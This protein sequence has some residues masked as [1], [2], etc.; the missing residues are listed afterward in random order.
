M[1]SL[2]NK[3]NTNIYQFSCVIEASDEDLITEQLFARGASSVSSEKSSKNTI[4]LTAIFDFKPNLDGLNLKRWYIIER[5]HEQSWK[6]L[7]LRNYQGSEINDHI[8]ILP[9]NRRNVDRRSHPF[10]I[11][12][13]PRNAFG[14]GNHP[15]TFLCLNALD[16]L[17]GLRTKKQ[18]AEMEILDIGTGTGILA[19]LCS[20]MG[21]R[22][23]TA[24]DIDTDS[25]DSARFNS[26]LNDC[27][28]IDFTIADI[29]SFTTDKSYDIVIANILT[30]DIQSNFGK[31][32]SFIKKEG[33]LIVSGISTQWHEEMFDIFISHNA[34]LYDHTE[35]D[36]WN[37]YVLHRSQ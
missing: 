2:N 29:S 27:E 1:S 24:F 15:T 19:I 21:V 13:D 23:V 35:K 4:K 3:N 18:R 20:L 8:M 36:D 5:I 33:T 11:L 17:L 9:Y 26:S 31:L 34:A 28:N 22:S 10:T 6:N 7:W 30:K 16:R 25:I 37:C 32:L 12:L 14:D